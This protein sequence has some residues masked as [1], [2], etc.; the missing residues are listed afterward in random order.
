MKNKIIYVQIPDEIFKAHMNPFCRVDV[1][2]AWIKS[3][4]DVIKQV[5]TKQ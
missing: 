5:K 2:G 4:Q 3:I 1:L